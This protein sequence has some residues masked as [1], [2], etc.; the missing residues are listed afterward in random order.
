MRDVVYIYELMC[1]IVLL[2]VFSLVSCQ[3]MTSAVLGSRSSVHTDRAWNM[4]RDL[5]P[6]RE[7]IYGIWLGVFEQGSEHPHIRT[8]QS[9]IST[10][11]RHNVQSLDIGK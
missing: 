11:G 5:D 1:H 2:R 4:P 8:A 9:S 3:D 6:M 7:H 10:T